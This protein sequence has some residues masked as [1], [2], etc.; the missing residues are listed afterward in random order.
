[1]HDRPRPGWPRA[2]T[3]RDDR[4]IVLTHLRDRFRPATVTAPT[5]NVTAQTIRNRLRACQ[6]PIRAGCPY[7]GGILT[8]RHRHARIWVGTCTPSLAAT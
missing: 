5:F 8:L 3:Q 1:M 2:T 6:R 4:A 7:T